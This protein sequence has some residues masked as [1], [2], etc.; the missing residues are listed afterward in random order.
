MN[1]FPST[2]NPQ[3][4]SAKVKIILHLAVVNLD[5]PFPR[6]SSGIHRM[7][8]PLFWLIEPSTLQ[9]RQTTTCCVD[10]STATMW[11]LGT[12]RTSVSCASSFT[13]SPNSKRCRTNPSSLAGGSVFKLRVLSSIR[14]MYTSQ[15][16]V[17]RDIKN[18]TRM[19]FTL[20]L[21]R[22]VNSTRVQPQKRT[23]CN[24]NTPKSR[25]ATAT[26]AARGN[27]PRNVE[28][29]VVVV[30]RAIVCCIVPSFFLV[31]VN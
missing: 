25:R 17:L 24:K 26:Y 12:T 29:A 23:A 3:R 8:P 30:H 4:G 31:P 15:S 28:T 2:W 27:S 22:A 16:V 21:S 10:F 9:D 1:L 14:C 6:H 19:R 20:V 18:C 7:T 13:V 5:H 11:G